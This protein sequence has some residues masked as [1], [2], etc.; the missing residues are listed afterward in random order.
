M[1]LSVQLQER[2]E[3]ASDLIIQ[4]IEDGTEKLGKLDSMSSK[5]V[6][7]KLFARR[8]GILP[9]TGIQIRDS[10]SNREMNF[11]RS[12]CNISVRQCE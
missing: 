7:L 10:I 8:L 9:L 6:V 11:K 4:S 3:N 2:P 5:E 1:N 12:I